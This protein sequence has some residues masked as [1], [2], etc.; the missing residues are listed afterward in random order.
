ME[1]ELPVVVIGA[2]LAGLCA[3]RSLARL[4]VPCVVLEAS[5]Q[6]GRRATSTA[7]YANGAPLERRP[8]S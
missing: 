3:A 1:P 2:G 6:P 8:P 7:F 4:G 5:Q